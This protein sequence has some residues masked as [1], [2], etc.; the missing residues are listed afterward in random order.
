MKEIYKLLQIISLVYIGHFSAFSQLPQSPASVLSPNAASLELYGDVP[1]SYY[2]GV[3]EISI[4]LYN[5]SCYNF[6]LPISLSYHASG[7]RP[8]QRPGWVGLG[9]SLNAGGVITRTVNA[10][11]DETND[12]SYDSKKGFY[13]K[14]SVLNHLSW[15]QRMYLRQIAQS[16]QDDGYGP[17]DTAPDEFSFNFAG[18]SGKFYM[19]HTGTWAVKCD[20]PVKV[21]FDNTFL[22]IPIKR[23]PAE[24]RSPFSPS[25]SG[26][27]II[28][29]D[30]TEYI[31]G[32]DTSSIEYSIDF[33][34]QAGDKWIATAWYLK[35]IILPNKQEVNFTYERGDYINQMYI[36]VHQDL[37]TFTEEPDK[38]W[39]VDKGC[40]SASFSTDLRR[41][42]QGSLIAPVYLKEVKTNN[43]VVT[44]DRSQSTELKYNQNIYDWKHTEWSYSTP[45]FLYLK[46]KDGYSYPGCLNNLK[47]YKL[48]KI[49]VKNI[50]NIAIKTI[51]F[52][53][54]NLATERLMLMSVSD[55]NKK[56]YTFEY[57]EAQ[58]LPP[59]LAN[60]TDHWGFYNGTY[61]YLSDVDYYYSYR[62]PNAAYLKYGTMNKMTYPTGGYTEFEFEPHRYRKQLKLKRWEGCDPELPTNNLAGGLRI[63]QIK[64]THLQGL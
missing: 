14:Y 64:T 23:D 34:L 60:K 63:K 56:T 43:T 38:F 2:T 7:V 22:N 29:E 15:N 42:Y 5:I 40:S 21:I 51:D 16:Q 9:W 44:F 53:Y 36:A 24:G 31:F 1:V 58:N 52:T 27:T 4:P 11:S 54:N 39:S 50:H 12:P 33:F 8:D 45:M 13:F 59:Y 32:G 26:F 18:Y 6:Q 3:P 30:G 57:D 55:Q 10:M 35:K 28:T 48:D 41:F 19:T 46:S 49:T 62:N 37:G 25:F 20:K 61:A 17:Q 47:W